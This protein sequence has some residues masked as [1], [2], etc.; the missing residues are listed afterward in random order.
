MKWEF[1]N[2]W[3]K[4]TVHVITAWSGGKIIAFWAAYQFEI[5]GK[6]IQGV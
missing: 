6:D 2:Y 4:D 3:V 5:T 1:D